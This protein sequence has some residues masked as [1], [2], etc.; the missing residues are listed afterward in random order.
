MT[1][2][3]VFLVAGEHSGDA[4][5][6]GLMDGLS[7]THDG[8]ITYAGVGGEAM[9]E[10]GFDSL[11]PL[12]DVAVMG[13]LSILPRLPRITRRV[14]RTVDAALAF[15]PDIVVIIDSPEFTHPI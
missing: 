2:L 14:Y 6:A 15:D 7:R 5:G 10:R 4:L 1:A 11:F 8:V 13:L 12:S 3:R 9:A